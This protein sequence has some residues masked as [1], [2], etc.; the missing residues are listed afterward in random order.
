MKPPQNEI[1]KHKWIV[2]LFRFTQ[3]NYDGAM[4]IPLTLDPA[5]P[6]YAHELSNKTHMTGSERTMHLRDPYEEQYLKIG[7]SSI[8]GT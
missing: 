4:A 7:E 3:L 2:D 6:F 1:W 5:G 8:Q